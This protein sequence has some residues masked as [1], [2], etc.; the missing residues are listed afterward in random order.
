MPPVRRIDK[1]AVMRA[2]STQFPRGEM[3]R[4]YTIIARLGGV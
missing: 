4:V 2:L 1:A 3:K